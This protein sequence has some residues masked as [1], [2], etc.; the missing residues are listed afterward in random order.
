VV[1]QI[2][3]ESVSRL[4]SCHTGLKHKKGYWHWVSSRANFLELLWHQ[5]S[6]KGSFP[7]PVTLSA[8]VKLSWS[9][10]QELTSL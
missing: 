7:R 2:I 10:A 1:T 8:F 4:M 9:L 5:L 3:G 6:L